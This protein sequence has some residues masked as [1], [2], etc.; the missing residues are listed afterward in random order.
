MKIF[1]LHETLN[2]TNSNYKEYDEY[3][4]LNKEI[5][6][7][8]TKDLNNLNN[9]IS[10]LSHDLKMYS[11]YIS[12]F[13][14]FYEKFYDNNIIIPNKIKL[15][16]DSKNKKDIFFI[17]DYINISINLRYVKDI[18]TIDE[19]GRTD[20]KLFLDLYNTYIIKYKAPY[21]TYFGK[22]EFQHIL[23]ANNKYNL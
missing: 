2:Y 15:L 17:D 9:F 18:K 6:N 23:D 1:K 16:S 3:S 11:D 13:V 4:I 12:S 7:Q 8:W 20:P 22:K 21:M 14:I 5:T 19:I 10:D